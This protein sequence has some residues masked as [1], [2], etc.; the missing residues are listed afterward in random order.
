MSKTPRPPAGDTPQPK[1]TH[2][3]DAEQL[4]RLFT[5]HAP[6]DDQP[7]RYVAVRAAAY[8]FAQAIVANCP[9][10]A[11][12]TAAIRK[13]REAVFTANAAIALEE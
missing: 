11:D 5:Y 1:Y 6:K 13:V 10:C 8:Q 3:E 2:R 4:K 9:N 12:R 7:E